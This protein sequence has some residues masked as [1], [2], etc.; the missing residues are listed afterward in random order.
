MTRISLLTLL[1]TVL[2]KPKTLKSVINDAALQEFIRVNRPVGSKATDTKWLANVI[3]G[4]LFTRSHKTITRSK[5]YRLATVTLEGYQVNKWS[6]LN[7]NTGAKY[8]VV[9]VEDNVATTPAEISE[10][11]KIFMQKIKS[12]V[13]EVYGPALEKAA[14]KRGYANGV[15]AAKTAIASVSI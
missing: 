6:P 2:A 10:A 11:D 14:Y 12:T 8:S 1:A 7:N 9:K 3:H 13:L 5:D 15:E 4:N